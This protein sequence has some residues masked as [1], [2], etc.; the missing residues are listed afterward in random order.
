MNIIIAGLGLIGGSFA[1]AIKE[2]TSHRVAGLDT[3]DETLEQALSFGAIDAAVRGALPRA[4]LVLVAL[5]PK[6]AIE[7]IESRRAEFSPGCVVIDLCGVKRAVCEEAGR[8]L[9]GSGVTF[10]GGHPMAGR[11][12]FGFGGA[13]ANLFMGASMILTPQNVPKET[14]AQMEAFFLELGFSG[15][16]LATPARHDELIALTSQL[17][18][19]V[20]SAYVQNPAASGHMGF[21]A[22]SFADMTRVAKLHEDMWTELFLLNADYLTQQTDWFIQK[23]TEFRN[24]IANGDAQHLQAML[25]AGRETKEKLEPEPC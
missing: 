21:S 24:A 14:L 25:R 12:A 19:V 13:Q 10:I 8:L 2:K 23:M 7:F 5:Y 1:K 4:D 18:H 16:T 15:V 22:G 3:N 20:S 17:A 9:E 6:A 11:E